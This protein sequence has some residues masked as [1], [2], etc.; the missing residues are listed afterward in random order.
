MHAFAGFFTVTARHDIPTG[1]F[2]AVPG[3]AVGA[4]QFSGEAGFGQAAIKVVA[5][6]AVVFARWVQRR[7]T[8]EV[9]REGNQIIAL[10]RDPRKKRG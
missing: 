6:V 5:N 1:I 8:D 2:F 3:G 4:D 9:L 7:N 10:A